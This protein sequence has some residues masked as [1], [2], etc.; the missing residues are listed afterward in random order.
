MTDSKR[1]IITYTARARGSVQ[2]RR[3][4]LVA[5][6]QVLDERIRALKS[7]LRAASN[8]G[9]V[10]KS[11]Y[12]TT[13]QFTAFVAKTRHLLLIVGVERSTICKQIA[14]CNR[15][16]NEVRKDGRRSSGGRTGV[17]FNVGS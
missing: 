16:L 2:E 11:L 9:Q 7:D 3:E 6:L 12:P 1:P 15:I 4:D 13:K 14:R 5:Q 17:P 10:R 8:D